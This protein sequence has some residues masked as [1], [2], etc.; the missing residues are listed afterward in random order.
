MLEC[1]DGA[2]QQRLVLLRRT[3]AGA[4]QA[5]GFSDLGRGRR[6]VVDRVREALRFPVEL[7]SKV[8]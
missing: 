4:E 3:V 2:V 7:P 5:E 6:E 8:N 1:L